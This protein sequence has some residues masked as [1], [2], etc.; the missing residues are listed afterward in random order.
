MLHPDYR[1]YFRHHLTRLLNGDCELEY[2]Y[3]IID[4]SGRERWLNQ[5]NV[6][7]ADSKGNPVAIEGIVRDITKRKMAEIQLR[8]SERKLS[9]LM[10]NLPGMAYRCHN[11]SSWT[12]D[13]VSS[14]CKELTGLSPSAL[15][16]NSETSYADLILPEDQDEVWNR[17]QSALTEHSNFEMEYRIRTADGGHKHVWEKGVGIY[18]NGK[19]LFLEGFIND[20][21]EHKQ[22][23]EALENSERR[24]RNLFHS[25]PA[26]CFTFDCDGV[27]QDWNRAC[28]ELYGWTADEVIGKSMFA[29]LVQT[30]NVDQTRKQIAAVFQGQSFEGLEFEDVRADGSL[31]SVLVNHYP[32]LDSQGEVLYGLCA[33]LDITDRKRA[34]KEKE[35]LQSRLRQAQKMEALGTLA[36]GIAHDFN[37][38]LGGVMGYTELA[39]HEA[40]QGSKLEHKLQQ[41]LLAG[42]RAAELV[43]QILNFSRQTEQEHMFVQMGLI[44]K[45]A[46]KLLR[47]SAPS[48]ITFREDIGA[49]L[50]FVFAD[51]TQI[52]QVVMNLCTNAV[53]AMNDE[54][55]TL[56][57]SLQ[58]IF[59]EQGINNGSALLPGP[60]LKLCVKDTGPGIPS[61]IKDSI[62]DPYFNTKNKGQG[63]GLGLAMVYSIVKNLKGSITVANNPDRGATFEVLLP[64]RRSKDV[65]DQGSF[66][67]DMKNVEPLPSGYGH[68]LFVDDEPALVDVARQM[69]ETLGYSVTIFTNAV[70]AYEMFQS[71]PDLFDVV[72]TGQSMPQLSGDKLAGRILD[73]RPDMPIILCTGY[74]NFSAEQARSMGIKAFIQKPIMKED[75]A[76]AVAGVAHEREIS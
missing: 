40:R 47:S 53:Q 67:D 26:C 73:I 3:K 29:T 65:C 60:Y 43:Q 27:I 36:G 61:L 63:T 9:T 21:T 37:N 42:K 45:E 50:P 68:V 18:K 70:E 38:I 48:T 62:F 28:E 24:Y 14:G 58:E 76:K 2:D 31:C 57:I 56:S 25:I 32:F 39:M 17:V 11:D 30:K 64:V 44:V 66:N 59:W 72:I 34:E 35:A 54:G 71:D 20:I 51:P 16:G 6:F 10:A 33:G 46:T 49:D 69:L 74:S 5:T 1:G 4:K 12:M 55:G 8:E 22:S 15:I 41:V 19:I 52:H 13:F 23:K 7:V 75:L